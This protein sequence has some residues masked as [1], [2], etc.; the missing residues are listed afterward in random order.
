[1]E[2][3]KV[4]CQRTP[5]RV[6]RTRLDGWIDLTMWAQHSLANLDSVICFGDLNSR[7]RIGARVDCL[8]NRAIVLCH[9]AHPT[10]LSVTRQPSILFSVSWIFA[11]VFCASHFARE[12]SGQAFF[13]RM[14]QSG[15]FIEAPR[16]IEQQLR[17]AERS[18]QQDEDSDAVVRLGD[19]LQR[20]SQ[21]LEE[22]DLAGQDFFI[23]IDGPESGSRLVTNSLIRRARQIIGQLPP[24]ALDTYE[25]RYGPMA[26]KLLQDAASSRDWEAVRTVRRKYFHTKAGYESSLLLAQ[27]ELLAGHALAASLLLDDVVATP[28]AVQH[29]GDAVLKMHASASSIAGRADRGTTAGDDR[30]RGSEEF[31]GKDVRDYAMF[32]G[33]PD[34]NGNSA[35]QMPLT[36]MR[37]ELETTAS[38]RQERA[39]RNVASDLA[40]TGKLPPPSWMPLRVGDQLLMRTTERLVGV[41]Y[42]T[43]KRVWTWP[44]FSPAFNE[45]NLEF[46]S[47]PG[48]EGPG[49]LLSQR[50]WNDLPYGQMTSDGERVF[51][52]DDLG[53]VEV[54][55]FSPIG[56]GG[57]RP[58]DT[59][60]NTLVALDLA[61]EGK[62]LWRIGAGSEEASKLSGAFFLGPPLPLDGR[63]Y[64]MIELAGDIILSCLDPATGGELWRQQLVAVESGG[65]DVDPIRR[66]AGASPTYYEGL[67]ICPTGAGAVV[68]VDLSDRVLRWGLAFDRNTEMIRSVSGRG[69]LEATQLMQRWY[70]GTAIASDDT[71]LVTPIESDRLFGLELLTGRRRFA[72]KNRVHMRYLAGIRDGRFFVVGANQV[73][74]FDLH[75]GASIWTTSPEM[76]AAGQQVVGRGVFGDGD[77]LLPTTS[78][79][80]IRI[81]LA[82]GDVIE[83]RTTKYPLGNLV[84]VGGEIIVQ[85]TS[86][87]SVAYGEASLEPLVTKILEKNPN[88]FGALVRKSE[89]LI[90][91]G[92]RK[93]ALELLAR[94]R[95]M[96][97]TNDEVHMLSV[98]AM[99]GAL[100]ANLDAGGD[101]VE[102]LDRLIDRPSERAELL[103]LRIRS[104]LAHERYDEATELLIDLSTLLASQPLLEGAADQVVGDVARHCSLDSWVAARVNDVANN[105]DQENLAAVNDL[106]AASIQ[107]QLAGSNSLLSR[108]VRHF[109]SL[110][111]VAPIRAELAARYA[112][113]GSTLQLERLALGLEVPTAAGFQA[114]PNARLL[115]LAEAYVSHRFGED[116]IAALGEL[117]SRDAPELAGRITPLLEQATGMELKPTWANNVSLTWDSQRIHTR[118]FTV[119]SQRVA[120]TKVAAGKHFANWQLVS[121]GTN[122]LALRDPTG[123]LSPITIEGFDRRIDVDKEAQICGSFMVIV[124]PTELVGVDLYHV[125]AN[126]GES[127]LWRRGLSGDGQPIAK[128]RSETTPFDDQIVRYVITSDTAANS[129]PEFCL[130]PI[131]GDRVLVL[132][133]GDLMAI[134]L[135]T[136]ETLWR[137]STAPRSGAVLADD[138]RVAVVSPANKKVAFFDLLDGR[139]LE[140]SNWD[141]GDIWAS[142]GANVLCYS[143]T[144]TKRRYHVQLVNPFSGKVLL[145]CQTLAA[146][147]GNTDAP[148]SYGRVIDGR[149]CTLLDSDGQST[150]WDLVDA[151]NWSTETAGIF[152]SAG[153]SIDR[154]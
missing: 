118:G 32:G 70:S 57:T 61:T 9:S 12:A 150:I 132:Q 133:G 14:T 109:G 43:G 152:R 147:R 127:V 2:R 85:G 83:R 66:V 45:E 7:P 93:E 6:R 110:D 30:Y 131:L 38:P 47:V 35:G 111:G 137:N 72:E 62:L 126:D 99:L 77:Y 95:E 128:R 116:A 49:D 108:V 140:E 151:R 52:I 119:P 68:A 112:K 56:L 88:D 67:L 34:R 102:S 41:D 122:P 24:S 15:R 39:I 120:E 65:V 113:A 98:S 103:S 8:A 75:T 10:G 29:L 64:V 94:A 123:Q 104:A 59:G 26:R 148:C 58:S 136:S 20:D 106:V 63:L 90:Q 51:I 153:T 114:L 86:T 89:L 144:E 82:D 27:R 40:A 146:N 81:S 76:F 25:L 115:T 142:A 5:S 145:E 22:S 107:P 73:N 23:D 4:D 19:L 130:G 84:A 55:A 141:H 3:A 117:R 91:R 139:K 36:N 13:P 129:L 143:E 44:W 101:L 18:L 60:T 100:R 135:Q 121:E 53:E 50:V 134:D 138:G 154:P 1:M 54:A 97:P 16:G 28:R 42:R 96:E 71:L 105:T 74:A 17:E 78:N 149:Y 33:G 124:M 87:V 69:G 125:M 48:E 46:D 80:L 92:E 31:T 37:W 11:S 79:Q 21:S